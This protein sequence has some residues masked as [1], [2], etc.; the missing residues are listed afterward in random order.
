MFGFGILS[1]L[2]FLPL[3]GAA[4][5]LMQ[6]EGEA[7]D[8][9][10]RWIALWTTLV[11]FVLSLVAWARFDTAIA[12]FQLLEKKTWFGDTIIYQ[13]GVDGISMPFVLLTTLPDAAVHPGLVAVDPDPRAR[14][15][16]L[17]S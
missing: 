6:R 12:G 3:L 17:P 5:V 15:F 9:M 7:G 11:A 8:R 1:G 10:S 4:L 13:L 14:I 16:R 2:V